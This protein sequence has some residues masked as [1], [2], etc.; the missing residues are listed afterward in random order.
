MAD[1]SDKST[2]PEATPEGD[3]TRR[4]SELEARLEGKLA[5]RAAEDAA[6]QAREEA[7][8]A[9][10]GAGSA[11]RIM[12]DL[13]A[14]VAVTGAIGYGIDRLL[15]SEPWGLLVGLLGGFGLGFWMAVRRAM[16][17]QASAP[18][19]DVK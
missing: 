14:A 16:A 7:L 15:G 11:W 17:I 4:L 5:E 3:E 13:V 2:G 18:D 1:P 6:A 8:A 10:R 12:I 9:N 19:G